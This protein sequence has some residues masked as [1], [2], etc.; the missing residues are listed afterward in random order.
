MYNNNTEIR[1]QPVECRSAE[2]IDS[3][4]RLWEASVRATHHFLTEDDIVE[5]RGYLPL[6]FDNVKHLIVAVDGNN[7]PLA[8]MGVESGVLEMLFIA[9]SHIGTGIGRKL[10]QYGIDNLGIKEVTANEQNPT[11]TG[12]YKHLGFKEYK[13][14]DHDEQGRPFPLLYMRYGI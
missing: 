13:R 12:F 9:P 6:A 2:L 5:I 3:L 10:V 14:T 1:L 4:T 7:T 8:F 11:A